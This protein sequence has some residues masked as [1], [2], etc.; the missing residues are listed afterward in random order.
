MASPGNALISAIYRAFRPPISHDLRQTFWGD[1]PAMFWRLLT[2]VGRDVPKTLELGTTGRRLDIPGKVQESVFAN[3]IRK[4]V[5]RLTLVI[6]FSEHV[7]WPEA[8]GSGLSRAGVPVS[9]YVP[10]R[11][12][13]HI[14][15]QW[16]DDRALWRPFQRIQP[17]ALFQHARLQPFLDQANDPG[18]ANPVLHEPDQPIVADRVERRYDRLPTTKTFRSRPLSHV[19]GIRL[20]GTDFL[21]SGA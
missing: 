5:F 19:N 6:G 20:K 3:R 7:A 15:Q 8:Q 12:T 10:L 17:L 13:T 11:K 14:R 4:P 9:L 1:H 18:V 21:S 16:R 2:G